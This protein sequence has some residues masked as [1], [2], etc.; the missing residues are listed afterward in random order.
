MFET[1]VIYGGVLSQIA[2]TLSL[3]K[4]SNEVE[5]MF[6][7]CSELYA[8]ALKELEKTRTFGEI[9]QGLVEMIHKA[10]YE[11]MTPQ[12]HIYNASGNMPADSPPQP[13]DYFTVHPNFANRDFTAGAKFG[14][15]VRINDK[16]KVERLQKTPAKLNIINI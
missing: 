10:G 15:T 14:D 1:N 3:G 5:K 4:T 8:Y 13:G 9:E 16:S 2:Y 6:Y 11:P 7:Y 12:M